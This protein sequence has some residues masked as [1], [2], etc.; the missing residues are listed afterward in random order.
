ML[1]QQFPGVSPTADFAVP[2][3]GAPRDINLQPTAACQFPPVNGQ[4]P[5]PVRKERKVNESNGHEQKGQ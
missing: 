2:G 1:S 4:E 5:E 3:Q